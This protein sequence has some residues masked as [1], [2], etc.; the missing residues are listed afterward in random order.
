M[1]YDFEFDRELGYPEVGGWR[2]KRY[3]LIAMENNPAQGVG[4]TKGDYGGW[5]IVNFENELR[6]LQIEDTSWIHPNACIFLTQYG[7]ITIKEN[8]HILS[9]YITPKMYIKTN[10]EA[11]EESVIENTT[12]AGETFIEG[13]FSITNSTLKNIHMRP[14][15]PYEIVKCTLTDVDAYYIKLCRNT[16]AEN[17]SIGGYLTDCYIKDSDFDSR[18]VKG[19]H[20]PNRRVQGVKVINDKTIV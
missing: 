18:M 16:V 11:H 2:L 3:R 19:H 15:A 7:N 8:T 12:I 5:V 1:K 10:G 20:Y 6:H 14:L 17:S 9:G 13:V 4:V